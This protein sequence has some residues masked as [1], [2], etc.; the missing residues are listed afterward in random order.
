MYEISNEDKFGLVGVVEN[1]K[2]VTEFYTYVVKA[3]ARG[4]TEHIRKLLDK[5]GLAFIEEICDCEYDDNMLEA[6]YYV[7]KTEDLVREVKNQFEKRANDDTDETDQKL[8]QLFGF[9]KTAVE[10]YI[11]QTKL[12]NYVDN[13]PG[14]GLYIHSPEHA[15]EEYE[16]YEARIMPAFEQYCPLSAREM[17]SNL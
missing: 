12:G 17:N 6:S 10:W 15:K 11:E 1:I 7:S 2:P 5:L 16:Q 8:G 13:V 14:Y 9:P 3:N 4:E